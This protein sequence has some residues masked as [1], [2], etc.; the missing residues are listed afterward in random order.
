M[1]LFENIETIKPELLNYLSAVYIITS[2][3]N[4]LEYFEREFNQPN[5]KDYHLFFLNEVSDDIIRKFADFDKHDVVQS[6]Q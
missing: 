4:H 5:F 6:I 2:P 1:F 3:Q